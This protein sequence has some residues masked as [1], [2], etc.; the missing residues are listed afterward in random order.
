MVQDQGLDFVAV[1]IR[2]RLFS[3]EIQYHRRR[4]AEAVSVSIR[5]RLFSREIQQS[6]FAKMAR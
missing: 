4:Y 3:R 1:S 6:S 2:S 5:S